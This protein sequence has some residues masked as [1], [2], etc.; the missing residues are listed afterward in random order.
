[1]QSAPAKTFFKT[2]NAALLQF[3]LFA[4]VLL[5]FLP[6]VFNGFTTYDD[7]EYVSA[8]PYV[9]SSLTPESFQWAFRAHGANWHPLTC[10][11][12]ILDGQI[13]GMKPWGHHLT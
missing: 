11:S 8:N 3:I 12:H 13:Y 1:M 9:Q 7:P 2:D 6:A 4:I 10:L 5:A